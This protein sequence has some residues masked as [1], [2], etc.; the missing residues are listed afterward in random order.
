MIGISVSIVLSLPCVY[1]AYAL[2]KNNY[3]EVGKNYGE[4]AASYEVF[5]EVKKQLP[6]LN[7]CTSD[8]LKTWKTLVAAK[9]MALYAAPAGD[10]SL[11]LC[12]AEV[13]EPI[14]H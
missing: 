7:T 2:T 6:L 11:A 4:I 1:I 13:L 9:T 3:L 10:S 5:D 8:Q 12:S 14:S